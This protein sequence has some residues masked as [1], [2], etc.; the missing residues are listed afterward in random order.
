MEKC[1]TLKALVKQAKQKKG[2]NYEKINTFD[3]L[4]VN[5]MVQK[6]IKKAPKKK[7]KCTEEQRAV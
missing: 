1:I 5:I 4:E 6:Q 3:K 7:K 2:K